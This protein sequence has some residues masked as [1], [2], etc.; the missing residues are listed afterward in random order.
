MLGR[1]HYGDEPLWSSPAA[2]GVRNLFSS[3]QIRAVKIGQRVLDLFK[4]P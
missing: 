1:A 3:G 2:Q 4:G